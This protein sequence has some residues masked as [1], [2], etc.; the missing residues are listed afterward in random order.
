MT[1]FHLPPQVRWPLG[2]VALL[3][4]SVVIQMIAV[5]LAA[6]DPSFAVEEDYERKA[7]RYDEVIAQ[8]AE[9]ERLGWRAAVRTVPP[10]ARRGAVEVDVTLLDAA[11]D[12]IDDADVE[13]ETCHLA[14]AANIL[15]ARPRAVG[16]G[17]YRVE[18]DM[19]RT[20]IW[21]F[22]IT[23]RRLDETFTATVR[24]DVLAEPR[25]RG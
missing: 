24:Q 17:R 1:R 3:L 21:E 15:R 5:F 14:R 11:G 19:R 13:F 23:A 22:R 4:M 9:N 6:G 25:S 20:G 2:I 16:D 7:A 18:L 8:R 10:E 12:P